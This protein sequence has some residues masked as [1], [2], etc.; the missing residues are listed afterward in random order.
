MS[1]LLNFSFWFNSRPGNIG[2][3]A[4]SSILVIVGVCLLLC[5]LAAFMKRNRGMYYKIWLRLYNFF[6]TNMI[7][8]V[9]VAFFMYE[10]LPILSAR[11]LFLFWGVEFLVWFGFIIRDVIKIPKIKEAKAKEKEYKKYIP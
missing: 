1:N 4:L 5:V 6:L 8:G 7:I 9:F 10:S 2:V 11:V 3:L